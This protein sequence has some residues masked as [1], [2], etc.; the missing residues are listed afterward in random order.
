MTCPSLLSFLCYLVKASAPHRKF[1]FDEGRSLDGAHTRHQLDCL[2]FQR[3]HWQHYHRYN[4]CRLCCCVRTVSC[5]RRD[6]CCR[7]C[8][9]CCSRSH[10]CH[11]PRQGLL[12]HQGSPEEETGHTPPRPPLWVKQDGALPWVSGAEAA[13][14]SDYD[15]RQII[16]C[17][18]ISC[19]Q[20]P[21]KVGRHPRFSGTCSL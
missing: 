7:S 4:C 11:A 5:S 2:G 6:H 16:S 3:H 10:S 8:S 12:R 18:G 20:V 19:K 21:R 1:T 14:A 15:Y 13:A 17:E 9:R